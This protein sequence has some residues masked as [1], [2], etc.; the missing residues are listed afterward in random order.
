MS[1]LLTCLPF[2]H[3]NQS[4]LC[5]LPPVHSSNGRVSHLVVVNWKTTAENFA[6]HMGWE[7]SFPFQLNSHNKIIIIIV[8][9]PGE[10]GS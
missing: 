4:I 1:C 9:V 7:S 6:L 5:S 10:V 2:R 3:E 8:C